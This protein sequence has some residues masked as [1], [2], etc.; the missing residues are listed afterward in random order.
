VFADSSLAGIRRANAVLES[1]RAFGGTNFLP[2]CP[3]SVA[4]SWTAFATQY[5]FEF[6]Q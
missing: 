2:A 6:R 4:R 1:S 5:Q 3:P